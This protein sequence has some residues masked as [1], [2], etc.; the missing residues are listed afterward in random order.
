MTSDRESIVSKLDRDLGQVK[1]VLVSE[2]DLSYSLAEVVASGIASGNIDMSPSD[3]IERL[4][5]KA[6]L[7][8]ALKAHIIAG[9]DDLSADTGYGD[10]SESHAD[11]WY[12]SPYEGGGD[13]NIY[14]TKKF[15]TG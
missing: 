2:R 6:Y 4:G 14:V 15:R 8:E 13:L 1:I 10:I 12:P 9:C 11:V 3:I 7:L 5:N